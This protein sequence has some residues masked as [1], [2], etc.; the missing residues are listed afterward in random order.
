MLGLLYEGNCYGLEFLPITQAAASVLH[1]LSFVVIS[2]A[3]C[4][5]QCA[6]SCKTCLL[7]C[8][9][10]RCQH[11]VVGCVCQDVREVTEVQHV[12]ASC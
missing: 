8:N 4:L 9:E 12:G 1:C 7:V 10:C 11:Y 5:S 6:A 3:V 2:I